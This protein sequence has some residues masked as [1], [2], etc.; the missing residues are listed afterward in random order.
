M[1]SAVHTLANIAA[2]ILLT[3]LTPLIVRW[4]FRRAELAGLHLSAEKEAQTEKIVRDI[5]LRVEEWAASRVKVGVPLTAKDK[6]EKALIAVVDKVPGITDQEAADLI[7]ATLPKVGAG[8][9]AFLEGVRQAA[10]TGA[11]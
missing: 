2:S 8:A 3:V 6:F 11:R 4:I 10:T 9:A 7:H 5:I 1:D